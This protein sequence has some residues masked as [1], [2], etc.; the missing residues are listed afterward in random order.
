VNLPSPSEQIEIF[1]IQL[2]K[3]K[4]DPAKFNIEKLVQNSKDLSGREIEQVL[5]EAMYDSFYA[6]KEIDTEAIAAVLKKKTNLLST[7]AE[8]L[9][10]ILDWVEWDEDKKDGKRARFASKSDTLNIF[11]VKDEI[12]QILK[13]IEKKKPFSG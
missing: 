9:K 12:D 11:K 4:R 7:M 1:K 8:Q 5:K 13:D 2:N 3:L 10:F 6:G